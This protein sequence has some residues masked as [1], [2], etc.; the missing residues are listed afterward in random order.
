[1]A[2][3]IIGADVT[4]VQSDIA[5]LKSREATYRAAGKADLADVYKRA[6]REFANPAY[7]G[8]EN[9]VGVA[10]ALR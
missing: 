5:L 9:T 10:H 6:Y 2:K 7:T 8:Q 1:M 4:Q 3:Q